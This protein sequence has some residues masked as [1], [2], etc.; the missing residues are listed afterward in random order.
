MKLHKVFQIALGLSLI[1][2]SLIGCHPSSPA[3]FDA[4]AKGQSV[5]ER[6]LFWQ[7]RSRPIFHSDEQ[8]LLHFQSHKTGMI[9]LIQECKAQ[10]TPQA[11]K[12]DTG[13]PF[14]ACEF[15]QSRLQALSLR[16]VA[17]EIQRR[18]ALPGEF[19]GSRM[20]LVTDYYKNDPGNT[21]VEEK[22]F[23][24]SPRPI[25][26]DVIGSGSLDPLMGKDLFE[27]RGAQEAWRYKQ[28]AP[29][30]YLYYRQYFRLFLN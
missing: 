18:N 14:I 1:A 8:L 10:K 9:D 29:N 25:Q 24:Y 4:T 27:R 11:P 7:N 21:F 23:V 28:I 17:G 19:E 2:A 6:L 16:E 12:V 15:D 22:G 26:K 20:V 5:T 30:W 3:S 13:H